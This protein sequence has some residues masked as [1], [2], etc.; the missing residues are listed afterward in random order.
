MPD[1]MAFVQAIEHTVGFSHRLQKSPSVGGGTVAAWL[2]CSSPDRAV[3]VRALAGHI[4]LC[5]WATHL[6]LTVLLST[7]VYKWVPAIC[8]G[9]LTNCGEI[10]SDKSVILALLSSLKTLYIPPS[11]CNRV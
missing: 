5:S 11:T 6:T 4:V 9:N 2:A 7:Q 10:Y 8:W 3:Q 1:E